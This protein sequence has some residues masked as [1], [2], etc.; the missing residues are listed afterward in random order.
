MA[1]QARYSSGLIGLGSRVFA[2]RE[3]EWGTAATADSS[4]GGL[5]NYNIF[6]QPGSRPQKNFSAIEI[7]QLFP[8]MFRIKPISGRTTVTGSYTFALPKENLGSFLSLITGDTDSTGGIYTVQE[9]NDVS[10]T[11]IQTVGETQALR[12]TGMKANSMTFAVSAD[13]LVTFD[14][15]FMGKDEN[16]IKRFDATGI[17]LLK[18]WFKYPTGETDTAEL[19]FDIDNT[20]ERITGINSAFTGGQETQ[21]FDKFVDLYTSNEAVLTVT[22]TA[23][24]T[25]GDS[26]VTGSLDAATDNGKKSI[27]P[28]SDLSITVNNNLDFPPYV[29]GTA[30]P[31]EPVATGY[32]EVTGS[33]TVP[34]NSHTD[35]FI[36]GL[37]DRTCLLYTSPSPRDGLLSRMPSSA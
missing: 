18:E 12:Y 29:N 21:K 25:V 16:F 20:T 8:G 19:P 28:F 14:I 26:S 9:L 32:R 15:D 2:G 24:T 33:M 37:F 11:I 31:N 10:W 35:D 30:N 13:S 22:T 23:D 6:P 3:P 5:F 36:T 7:P 1:T 17:N 4:T 27:I 34:Y